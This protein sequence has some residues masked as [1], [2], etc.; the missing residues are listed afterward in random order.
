M[1]EIWK[2][3]TGFP[4]YE[5]SNIGRVRSPNKILS[6]GF[7][8]GYPRYELRLDGRPIYRRIHI[9]VCEAFNGPRPFP[10]A[11]CRHKD[12]NQLNNIPDNLCWGTQLD[13]MTDRE[14]AVGEDHHLAKLTWEK[15]RE[16]RRLNRLGISQMDLA[17]QF[18]VTQTNISCIMRNK[19]WRE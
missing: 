13:N 9:L 8:N 14:Y 3:I 5:V 16:I 19:T 15:V 18:N 4:G 10:N 17:V 2:P 11:L 1:E 12:D 6:P 7:V